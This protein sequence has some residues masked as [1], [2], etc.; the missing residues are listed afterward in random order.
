MLAP[1]R[2]ACMAGQA[3]RGQRLAGQRG[4]S[5]WLGREGLAAGFVRRG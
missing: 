1:L 2:P 3:E 5:D 4:A